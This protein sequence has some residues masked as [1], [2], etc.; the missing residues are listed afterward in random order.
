MSITTTDG[1]DR[2]RKPPVV[3]NSA[4]QELLMGEHTLGY[5]FNEEKDIHIISKYFV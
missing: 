3:T 2:V 5:K 4:W 1:M